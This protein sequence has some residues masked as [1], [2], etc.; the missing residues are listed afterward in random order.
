MI[1]GV[2]G[3]LG[4]LAMRLAQPSVNLVPLPETIVLPDGESAQSV[5]YGPG[6]YLVVTTSQTILVFDA[7]TGNIVQNVD[8]RGN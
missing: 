5:T 2:L 3:I 1:F 6:W 7:A 8:L 4:L